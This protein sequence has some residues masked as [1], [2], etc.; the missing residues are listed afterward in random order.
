MNGLRARTYNCNKIEI[1]DSRR[2][3]FKKAALLSGGTVLLPLLP[4]VIQKAFAIDPAPGSTFY[5]AEHIVFVMQENRSFDHI[6][7]SLKGVRGFNDPRAIRLA[8]GLPVWLQTDKSGATYAPFRLNT[9]DSRIAWMGSLPHGWSDQHDALNGGR[10]DRWLEVKAARKKE[11]AEMPLTL[12]FGDRRDFPFYYSL[13]DAFTVCDQHFCSSLTGTHSNRYHWM[14]GALRDNPQDGTSKAHV[15]NITD[16]RKPELGWKTYPERLQEAGVSWRIYQNELTMGFGIDNGEWLGNFGT[17]MLEFFGQ[18]NIRLQP[19]RIANLTVKRESVLKLIESLQEAPSPD[20]SVATRLAAAKKLL[21]SIE[22]DQALYTTDKYEALSPQQKELAARAFTVNSGDPDYHSVTALEY[23]EGA[24]RRSLNIPKGDIL[25]QFRQDV[26]SGSLP[27]VSW[28][29]APGNF[30]DHSAEPWFG[31]WYVS[32]VMDILLK[33]PEVWKKTVMVLTYDENDGFYDHMV[34]FVSP[35][36]TKAD[37]G[38][39]SKG[40]DLKPEYVLNDEQVNPSRS[41]ALLREG[42]IGLGYRVPMVIASPWTRGGYVCSEV[43]DHTSSLQF[44][45][46]FLARKTGRQIVEPNIS[47]WRRTVTGDLTSA[48]RPYNGERIAPP[49]FIDKTAFIEQVNEAQYKDLPKGFHQLTPEEI[50]QAKTEAPLQAFMPAQEPGTRPACAL[51]YELYLDGSLDPASGRY[52]LTFTVGN[53]IF[54]PASAGSPFYVYSITPYRAEALHCRNYAVRAGDTLTDD[55]LLEA[56][57][58]GRY[59]LR[60]YGPNGFY[61]EFQGNSDSA[62]VSVRMTYEHAGKSRLTGNVV[63]MLQNTGVAEKKVTVSDRSYGKGERKITLPAG[64][65]KE[66]VLDLSDSHSWYDIAVTVEGKKG[67]EERFAGRVETGKEGISDPLM[68]RTL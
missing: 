59:H 38:K 12:G 60:A 45:E 48:F 55:W 52:K 57:E 26:E 41:A 4:P 21:A 63:V 53:T 37:A 20:E 68:G 40:I 54:G 2:E 15:W 16:T 27:T 9:Q 47:A 19:G 43:F 8:N 31:P 49:A 67:F 11:Y 42:P 50:A 34:P 24:D 14:T 39:A 3:F 25:H 65:R 32:E 28:L 35:H 64:A 61:R 22:A 51:P 46:K 36:P 33:N 5:D 58:E 56:F 29:S 13:A 6:F 17:N 18:Y 23:G 62:G 7:G 1:M 10:Y 44:L 66:I 30:S